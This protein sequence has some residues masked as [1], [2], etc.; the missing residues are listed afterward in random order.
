MRARA[1]GNIALPPLGVRTHAKDCQGPMPMLQV[2][3]APPPPPPERP[4]AAPGDSNPRAQTQ[5]ASPKHG[6]LRGIAAGTPSQ[7]PPA[8]TRVAGGL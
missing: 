6:C 2:V 5:T 8:T 1:R 4:H 3:R 7:H